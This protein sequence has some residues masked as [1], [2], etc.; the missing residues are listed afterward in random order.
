MQARQARSARW[1]PWWLYVLAIVLTN[2]LRIQ[3]LQPDDLATWLEIVIGLTSIAL[4]AAAVTAIWRA[5]RR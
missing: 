5:T 2:Q 3:L 1:A 4:V